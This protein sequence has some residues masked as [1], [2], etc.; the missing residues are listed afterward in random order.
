MT[1]SWMAC[2]LAGV[3]LLG[4]LAE[5]RPKVQSADGSERARQALDLTM[6]RY[7]LG[8]DEAVLL[9][10]LSDL[11]ARNPKFARPY[12]AKARHQFSKSRWPQALLAYRQFLQLNNDPALGSEVEAEAAAV[13]GVSKATDG[14]KEQ[15]ALEKQIWL[16]RAQAELAQE[17]VQLATEYAARAI[18]LDASSGLGYALLGRGL[19]RSQQL[20]LAADA[21]ARAAE[22]LEKSEREGVVEELRAV[23]LEL[24]QRQIVALA[25]ASHFVGDTLDSGLRYWEA[26]LVRPENGELVVAAMTELLLA[27]EPELAKLILDLWRGSLWEG[28]PQNAGVRL[29]LELLVTR[30]PTPVPNAA[31]AARLS[32]QAMRRPASDAPQA[33]LTELRE[34]VRLR[35]TVALYR[36][37]LGE[38]LLRGRSYADAEQV[39]KESVELDPGSILARQRLAET[40]L[41]QY[42]YSEAEALL[43]PLLKQLPQDPLLHHLLGLALLGSRQWDAA[44]QELAQALNGGGWQPDLHAGLVAAYEQAG[45]SQ[46]ATRARRFSGQSASSS[47][48]S[49]T[50]PP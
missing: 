3:L 22:R 29:K 15:A 40:L 38:L 5:A 44:A 8:G 31:E 19:V 14:S 24:R 2:S 42:R 1:R 41:L 36:L 46:L 26:W 7:Q 30:L 25:V 13:E 9:K 28:L 17:H 39:L 47:S 12:L 33:A 20:T 27:D 21:L 16:R 6:A 34:A 10:A 4:P 35:P 50:S 11:E 18:L 23:R 32:W 37:L 43:R 48:K 45:K 49:G